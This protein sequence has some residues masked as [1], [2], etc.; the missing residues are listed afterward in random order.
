MYF[1]LKPGASTAIP[2]IVMKARV[3][4]V[5]K[6]FITK[7]HTTSTFKTEVLRLVSNVQLVKWSL[8]LNEQL[9]QHYLALLWQ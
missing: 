3:N 4:H 6:R 9:T 1:H 8:L 2:F 7:G 5:G